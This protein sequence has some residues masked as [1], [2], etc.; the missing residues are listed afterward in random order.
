MIFRPAGVTGN[1]SVIFKLEEA[2]TINPLVDSFGILDEAAGGVRDKWI[3]LTN[4]IPSMPAGQLGFECELIGRM[5]SG[6]VYF[7]DLKIEVI[8]EPIAFAA[9]LGV[10]FFLRKKVIA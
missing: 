9:F 3:C 1:N 10:V 8:P 5:S 6:T 4:I 2:G 7:D